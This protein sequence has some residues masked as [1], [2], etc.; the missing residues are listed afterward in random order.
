MN[1]INDVHRELRKALRREEA[2]VGF[3]EEVVRRASATPPA[4]RGG[5][6]RLA[7]AAAL[8]AAVA[9]GIEYRAVRRERAEGEAAKAQVVLALHLAGSKLQLVQARINRI[10]EPAEKNSNQ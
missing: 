4:A 10:G 7:A 8:I 3:A 5:L 1:E 9:G 2:P 6:F